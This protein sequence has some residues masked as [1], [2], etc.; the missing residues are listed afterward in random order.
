[1]PAGQFHSKVLVMLFIFTPVNLFLC[2]QQPAGHGCT[3]N[4]TS[5]E[6]LI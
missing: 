2:A 1:M 3:V 5:N 6:C 4:D